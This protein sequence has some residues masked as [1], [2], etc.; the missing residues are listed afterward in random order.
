MAVLDADVKKEPMSGGTDESKDARRASAF[1]GA[2]GSDAWS[3]DDDESESESEDE[4]GRL[5]DSGLARG[6]GIA[7]GVVVAREVDDDM[8]RAGWRNAVRIMC[9]FAERHALLL[10]E[11][12]AVILLIV[13]VLQQVRKGSVGAWSFPDLSVDVTS[14]AVRSVDLDEHIRVLSSD[15]FEG[16]AVGTNGEVLASRYI[17]SELLSYGFQP[18]IEQSQTK[19]TTGPP[20]AMDHQ[21]E[22]QEMADAFVQPVPLRVTHTLSSSLIELGAID[23]D[24]GEYSIPLVYAEQFSLTTDMDLRDSENRLLMAN[25]QIV[26]GGFCIQSQAHAWDD[27]KGVNLTDRVVLCL[28]NQPRAPGNDHFGGPDAPLTYFG[29]W[30]YKLEEMRRRHA[31]AV[32]LVHTD[33]LAGYGWNVIKSGA[34]TGNLKLTESMPRLLRAHGWISSDSIDSF[35]GHGTTH[36]LLVEANAADFQAHVLKDFYLASLRLDVE[37]QAVKGRN[38]LGILP[39]RSR[40]E[41]TVVLSA[42]LDHLGKRERT[43]NDGDDVDESSLIYHGALDNASGVAK[44]LSVARAVGELSKRGK[45]CA[46]SFVVF[47]PTAEEA[48]LLGSDYFVHSRSAAQIRHMVSNVNFD[49]MNIWGRTRD[50]VGLGAEKSEL[51]KWFEHA[52]AKERLVTSPD[53]A[54][55]QGLYFRSDQLPFARAGVPAIKLTHGLDYPDV[56]DVAEYVQN[57]VDAYERERYHQVTDD[58]NYIASQPDPYSGALQEVRVALRLIYGLLDSSIAP[59]WHSSSEF[60]RAES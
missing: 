30:T 29:R 10:A 20:W 22:T 36:R 56:A 8:A 13:L 6:G 15:K 1:R 34:L 50:A 24:G 35:A 26:F 42:H 38:V 14:S 9:R 18:L 46:R 58:Y 16:R 53:I 37:Q 19:H 3:S 17:A 59:K 4:R 48:G 60:Q 43:A 33:E 47:S 55:L 23:P 25:E 39:G 7:D 51:G 57:T 41:E 40:P 12:S 5:V 49:G 2:F 11:L 44:M 54:P 27:F 52:A 31:K 21:T 28:V 32:L 45:C